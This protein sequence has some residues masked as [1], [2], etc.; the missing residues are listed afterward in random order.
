MP[1][2]SGCP[3][4]DTRCTARSTRAPTALRRVA[5]EHGCY[6]GYPHLVDRVAERFAAVTGKTLTLNVDGMLAAILVQFGWSAEQIFGATILALTPSLVAHGDRGARGRPADAHHRARARGLRGLRRPGG[7]PMS[8]SILGSRVLRTEDPRL[9]TVGGTYLDD[10][11]V[12]GLGYV[13]YVRSPLAHALITG[14]GR[15]GARLPTRTS[16]RW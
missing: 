6:D 5:R 12:P 9:L 15:L 13:T 16:S 7:P 11:D 3:G 8:G 4:W 1:A 10:V 2:A 14:L